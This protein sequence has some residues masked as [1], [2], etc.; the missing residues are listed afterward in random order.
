MTAGGD[1]LEGRN[2]R[3]L[4]SFPRFNSWVIDPNKPESIRELKA[5][6]D[7]LRRH[8]EAMVEGKLLAP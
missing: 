2:D 3:P 5:I 4:G 6:R 7:F 1:L 8:G